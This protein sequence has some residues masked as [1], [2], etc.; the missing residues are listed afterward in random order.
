MS[1]REFRKKHRRGGMRKNHST[2]PSRPSPFQARKNEFQWPQA[3]FELRGN[4]LIQ[5]KKIFQVIREPQAGDFCALGARLLCWTPPCAIRNIGDATV[6]QYATGTGRLDASRDRGVAALTRRRVRYELR[7]TRVH[8]PSPDQIQKFSKT[9]CSRSSLRREGKRH[10]VQRAMPFPR[11]PKWN[12]CCVL[13]CVVRNNRLFLT[14]FRLSGINRFC[15][16][17]VI[18][19]R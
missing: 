4:Q 2:L 6:S 1:L 17:A 18:D 12:S 7:S 10:F 3:I 19:S 5:K 13:I 9:W 16:P 15:L 8:N 11:T 14:D